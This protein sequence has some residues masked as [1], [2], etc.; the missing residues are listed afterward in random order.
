M[1]RKITT[2]AAAQ[3]LRLRGV[4]AT[5]TQVVAACN[6]LC[7]ALHTEQHGKRKVYYLDYTYDLA[8]RLFDFFKNQ[9]KKPEI[10]D[11]HAR[12]GQYIK[13]RIAQ[14]RHVATNDTTPL[15]TDFDRAV[16]RA[17]DRV[18]EGL[19]MFSRDYAKWHVAREIA[20]D[21][22]WSIGYY[23]DSVNAEQR[24]YADITG[25]AYESALKAVI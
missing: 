10:I 9:P 1:D 3:M 7:V 23:M 13:L 15:L 22:G 2:G 4:Q 14:A 20:A 21:M 5:H 8:D 24:E 19:S 17:Y 16:Y 6:E 12:L 11:R 25:R 18:T